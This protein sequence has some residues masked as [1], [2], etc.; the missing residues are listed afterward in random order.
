MRQQSVKSMRNVFEMA[1]M[2]FIPEMKSTELQP[3]LERV[4]GIPNGNKTSFV[5]AKADQSTIQN[6]AQRKS[7][8]GKSEAVCRAW[9]KRL[10]FGSAIECEMPSIWKD[11]SSSLVDDEMSVKDQELWQDDAAGVFVKAEIR[12]HMRGKDDVVMSNL[13][14]E[15]GEELGMEEEYRTFRTIGENNNS[16]CEADRIP[17]LPPGTKVT[18]AAGSFPIQAETSGRLMTLHVEMCAIRL[19]QTDTDVVVTVSRSLRTAGEDTPP[20]STS[21]T[22]SRFIGSFRARDWKLVSWKDWNVT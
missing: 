2:D 21:D 4:K 17:G 14:H 15:C 7:R 12:R 6:G 11:V 8:D 9:E 19:V 13:V 3:D 22:F 5:N 20:A 10:L 16:N 18:F 1:S